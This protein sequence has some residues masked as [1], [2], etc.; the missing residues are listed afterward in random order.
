MSSGDATPNT[1]PD[2]PAALRQLVT[3][4]AARIAILEEQLRLATVKHIVEGHGGAV[5]AVK[6]QAGPGMTLTVSLLRH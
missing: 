2:D 1:V 4:Q 3:A 5:V 6:N